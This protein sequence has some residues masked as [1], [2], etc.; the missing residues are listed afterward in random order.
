MLHRYFKNSFASLPTRR[1][2]APL[3]LPG[4]PLRLS[5]YQEIPCASLPT[6]R[7]LAPLSL[8][9]DS[10]AFTGFA[11]PLAPLLKIQKPLASQAY[12]FLSLF[13]YKSKLLTL[14][15]IKKPTPRSGF[16]C[17]KWCLQESNQGHM[18]FQSIALPTELRH[19]AIKRMQI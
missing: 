11:V 10:F 7:S 3:S 14:I 4:D 2:L 15:G 17:F 13:A 9:G 5:P 19:H 8:P 18:D 1:S 16:L 6:R 12:V